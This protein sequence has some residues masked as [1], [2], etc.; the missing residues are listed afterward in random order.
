MNRQL[1]FVA[2]GLVLPVALSGG[3]VFAVVADEAVGL[4]EERVD[5]AATPE[6]ASLTQ[7]RSGELDELVGEVASEME[8]PIHAVREQ[9]QAET[10]RL[11]RR[12]RLEILGMQ[13]EHSTR[14]AML[15]W[16]LK[17]FGIAISLVLLL[18]AVEMNFLL[19]RLRRLEKRRSR[20]VLDSVRRKEPRTREEED[21]AVA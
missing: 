21:I 11:N 8:A 19:R 20:S 14:T 6:A 7:K 16:Q 2:L 17:I 15:G 1:F 18:V 10:G 4:S 12:V 5:L 3:A 9:L 13:I